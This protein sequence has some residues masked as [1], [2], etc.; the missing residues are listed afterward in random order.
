MQACLGGDEQAFTTL[1]D[2][3]L[4]A[5]HR[6]L[7]RHSQSPA[8]ADELAQETFLKLW[9]NASSF[10]PGKA[11]LS[12]WLHRIAHN[13]MIDRHRKADSDGTADQAESSVVEPVT[14]DH[15]QG[16][17]TEEQLLWLN[18]Q[19]AM[20]PN[21]QRWA[22]AL[23]Y[24]QGF[25]NKEAAQIMNLGLRALESLLARGREKLKTAYHE[26]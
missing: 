7:L 13:L 20:L 22:M 14:A 11:R 8:D 18:K 17:D 15:S 26:Q 19:L 21:N 12:T 24:L 6:Y 25:S 3:H 2:R 16:S 5:I 9:T 1:L 23:V 4:D 10:T